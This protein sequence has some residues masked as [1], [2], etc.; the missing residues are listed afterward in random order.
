MRCLKSADERGAQQP[1]RL[2]TRERGVVRGTM[3]VVEEDD[4]RAWLTS[5]RVVVQPREA[6]VRANVV[7]GQVVVPRGVQQLE[8]GYA[9]LLRRVFS[10]R[11]LARSCHLPACVCDNAHVVSRGCE[12]VCRGHPG[13]HGIR[14]VRGGCPCVRYGYHDDAQRTPPRLRRQRWLGCERKHAA[15]PPVARDALEANVAS[16]RA[17]LARA[18]AAALQRA[19]RR[20]QAAPFVFP[21]RMRRCTSA[22]RRVEKGVQEQAPARGGHHH[23]GCARAVTSRT[24]TQYSTAE[25]RMRAEGRGERAGT[26]G[27]ETWEERGERPLY[28]HKH[29]YPH[30]TL[31]V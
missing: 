4:I 12:H 10:P 31:L 26:G 1:V 13:E 30:T 29:T 9:K 3:P 18:A 17:K 16:A 2:H 21:F 14:V 7:C 15:H 19:Q 6:L 20:P 22:S 24:R 23:H 5:Q 27:R 28:L 25:I 11:G 8:C